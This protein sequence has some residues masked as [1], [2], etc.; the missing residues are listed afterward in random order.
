VVGADTRLEASRYLSVDFLEAGRQGAYRMSNA[1]ATYETADARYALTAFV[2]NIE[3][4]VVFAN[5]LQSP[6]K[7]GVIY[8]Q[9]RPPRTYGLRVTAKF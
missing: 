3:D 1:R 6:A 7:A 4:K 5:S 9:V 8:N 2:N